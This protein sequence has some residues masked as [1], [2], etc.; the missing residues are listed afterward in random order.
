MRQVWM[1]AALAVLLAPGAM[2]Q[3][4]AEEGDPLKGR[5]IARLWCATCHV[6]EENPARAV[7]AAPTFAAIADKAGVTAEG[8]RAFLS[9]QH[10]G[11]AQGRM[12][13]LSLSRNDVDNVVAYLLSRR[14]R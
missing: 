6:V 12:P 8:L 14:G 11:G 13:N 10:S 3:A 2:A 5:E 4:P 1:G 9:A 7:D